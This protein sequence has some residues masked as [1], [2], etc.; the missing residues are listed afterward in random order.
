M[1]R[2]TDGNLTNGCR[3]FLKRERGKEKGKEDGE[4]GRNKGGGLAVERDFKELLTNWHSFLFAPY[5]N[6]LFIIM[7]IL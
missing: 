3:D 5:W 6:H 4:R 7:F 2:Q 1:D